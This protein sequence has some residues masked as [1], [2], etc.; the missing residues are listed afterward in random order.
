M[1]SGLLKSS[2]LARNNARRG[3]REATIGG[4]EVREVIGDVDDRA[5]DLHAFSVLHL[6]IGEDCQ[7]AAESGV[8]E[9][10][11]PLSIRFHAACPLVTI[12]VAVWSASDWIRARIFPTTSSASDCR[13]R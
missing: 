9:G 12:G 13:W 4:V 3:R 2:R 5:V 10:E 11:E 8:A 7:G 1:K 6:D